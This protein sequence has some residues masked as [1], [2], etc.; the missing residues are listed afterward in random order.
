M[1]SRLAYLVAVIVLL[2]G[3]G[4]VAQSTYET[5]LNPFAYESPV[6]AELF[7]L[8]LFISIILGIIGARVRNHAKVGIATMCPQCKRWRARLLVGKEEISSSGRLDFLNEYRCRYC[9]F[10]WKKLALFPLGGS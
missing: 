2:V 10:R 6:P 1:V 3:V 9:G 4:I 7:V 5:S 8:A